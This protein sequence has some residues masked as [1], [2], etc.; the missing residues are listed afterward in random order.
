MFHPAFFNPKMLAF[1]TGMINS[2]SY[3]FLQTHNILH[4]NISAV[5]GWSDSISQ[6]DQSLL[7]Y[8]SP[9]QISISSFFLSSTCWHISICIFTWFSFCSG[10][11]TP[12]SL[13]LCSFF[14]TILQHSLWVTP[15]FSWGLVAPFYW[16]HFCFQFFHFFSKT[17]FIFRSS[18]LA[19]P[20]PQAHEYRSFTQ[21]A[22]LPFA[23]SYL[24]GE[25]HHAGSPAASL[26]HQLKTIVSAAAP[27]YKSSL[28][29]TPAV[30]DLHGLCQ[31]PS[32][33]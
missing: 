2:S 21:G 8:I 31:R 30:P 15:L 14:S 10:S 22:H 33:G 11:S 1:A 6:T 16:H 7:Y 3:I 19:I 24:F 25:L 5:S 17:A 32:V 29:C 27:A 4:R 28:P 26:T 20:S 23:V 9:M 12:V 13:W 18:P